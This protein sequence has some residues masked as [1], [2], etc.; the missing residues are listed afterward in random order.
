[1]QSD[2][3]FALFV[4]VVLILGAHGESHP[5]NPADRISRG[6]VVPAAPAA[7]YLLVAAA[8]LVLIWR[9]RYPV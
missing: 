1:M 8:A 6:H 7:A 2:V 9:R 3:L 5:T 4:T